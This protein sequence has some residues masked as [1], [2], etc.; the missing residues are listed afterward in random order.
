MILLFDL[1]AGAY[2]LLSQ[3][4]KQGMYT[5]KRAQVYHRAKTEMTFIHSQ[6][7]ITN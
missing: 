4:K 3:S 6:F 2:P 7:R 5:I 1:G